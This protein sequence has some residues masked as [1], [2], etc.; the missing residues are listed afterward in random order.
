MMELVALCAGIFVF[1][2]VLMIFQKQGVQTDAVSRRLG[3]I[4]NSEKKAA[5]LDEEMNLPLSERIFK[6][7]FRSLAGMLSKIVPNNSANERDSARNQQMEKLKRQLNQAGFT[8]SPAEYGAIRIFVIIS[9]ALLL[10]VIALVLEVSLSQVILLFLLGI[11]AGYTGMRYF[12]SF[13]VQK[14]KKAMEQQLP[15]VLDLL[16][17]SVEAGLGFEQA[18]NHI[19]SNMEGPLIDEFTVTYREM[20][21]GR[22]RREALILLGERCNLEDVKSFAGALVQAGQ[23]GISMK[24]VL[25]SQASAMRQNKKAKIQEKA[26]K[27]SVKI[28]I[29]M[30]LFIFPV[31]FIVL[32]GPAVVNVLQTLG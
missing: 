26:M 15:D 23:L 11:F 28:L 16:S 5:I 9:T 2:T 12:L 14:R 1:A 27:V 6:P 8:I 7:F 25:R 29:P 30:L 13:M 4:G 19:V 31:I 17:V 22:T 24:N 10:S 20:S 21:M 32:M 18:V 3:S